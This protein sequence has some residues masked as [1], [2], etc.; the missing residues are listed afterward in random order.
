MEKEKL[1][2]PELP[3][4]MLRAT[5]QANEQVDYTKGTFIVNEDWFG[6]QNSTVNFLSDDGKWTLR[7]FQKENPGHELGCT[8][9]FGTIYGDKFY[10]VSQNREKDPGATVIGSRLAVIDA[11]TMKVLKE[12]TRIGDSDGRSFL[13]VDE[14]T[15]YIGTSN[16]IFLYDIDKMEIGERITGT[17]NT[18]GSLYSAQIGTMIRVGDRVFAVHQKDGLLVIDAKTHTLETTILKPEEHEGHGLGSIVLSK[19]GTIWA[20]PTVELTGT[21]AS[22]PLIWKVD[23]TTLTVQ[24]VDIPTASGIEEIPNS[25]YAW[26]ADGFCASTKENQDLLE[27]SGN[28]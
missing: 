3:Q 2:L 28:R 19:D 24:Q 6:H 15:G 9:Q 22:L 27:R 17:E 14:H 18:S 20:S 4:T 12:F 13:G 1:K 26:T 25:W 21:G 16:G 7:A 5:A 8:S 10:I 23:P 11:K